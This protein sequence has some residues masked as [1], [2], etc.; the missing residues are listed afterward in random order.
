MQKIK[1]YE[2]LLEMLRDVFLPRPKVAHNRSNAIIGLAPTGRLEHQKDVPWFRRNF[3]KADGNN[4]LA[5]A[6]SRH[7]LGF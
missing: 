4:R 6:A 1:A 3:S 7:F 5:T 2:K